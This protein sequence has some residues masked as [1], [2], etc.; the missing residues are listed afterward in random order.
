M[1]VALR[2]EA[3]EIGGLIVHVPSL[4]GQPLISLH[5][6]SCPSPLEPCVLWPLSHAP[7]VLHALVS[8]LPPSLL[9]QLPVVREPFVQH[10]L[11]A[12]ALRGA[13]AA[14]QPLFSLS[15]LPVSAFLLPSSYA[16]PPA[17][18]L[19]LPASS[20]RLPSDEPLP[21]P[22]QLLSSLSPQPL[23]GSEYASSLS[24]FQRR[25]SSSLL[26]EA[27]PLPLL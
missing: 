24:S 10:L 22:F 1:K 14:S 12:V 21:L 20:P 13:V 19:P 11:G 15:P 17:F 2:S 23:R 27:F 9:S 26:S 18:A 6:L 4:P 7:H 16:A 5:A 3:D 25:V 8:A